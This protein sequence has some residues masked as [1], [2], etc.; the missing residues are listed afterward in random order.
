MKRF[1]ITFS[2]MLLF[3]AIINVFSF[4]IFADVCSSNKC[5]KERQPTK[6]CFVDPD[7]YSSV[8][9]KVDVMASCGYFTPIV[10]TKDRNE[11]RF[12]L[13]KLASECKTITQ[14]RFAGHGEDG[15]QLVGD[16]DESSVQSLK[17]FGCLFSKN[18]EIDYMGCN[19]GKG[20]LGDMLLYQTAHTLLPNGGIVTAPTF[21]T[22][23][24]FPGILPHVSLNGKY[25]QL[26]FNSAKNPPDIWT[27]T[28]L[29]LTNGGS[30][31][32]RC[33]AELDS[34]ITEAKEAQKTAA[35]NGCLSPFFLSG[36]QFDKFSSLHA[37]LD[38]PGGLGSTNQET[39]NHFRNTL[40]SLQSQIE[41]ANTC[42]NMTSSHS[43]F[44]EGTR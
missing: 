6:I 7:V 44:G 2:A 3:W 22:S 38:A 20:C 17:G 39:W 18:A 4:E 27:Q 31:D 37:V 21:Y 36:S 15:E 28:G 9:T 11:I 14:M 35:K 23:S 30:I 8:L 24:P 5:P 41:M 26:S 43:W 10:V 16:L 19:V 32:K 25:R 1:R 40:F 33:S 42:N 29:T 13:E 34:L 12:A